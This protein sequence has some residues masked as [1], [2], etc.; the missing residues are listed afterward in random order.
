MEASRERDVSE[1]AVTLQELG[2]KG[3]FKKNS[4]SSKISNSL[5]NSLGTDCEEE[6]YLVLPVGGRGLDGVRVVDVGWGSDVGLWQGWG[7][8]GYTILV[9]HSCR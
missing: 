8:R 7:L 1:P 9:G 4:L 2:V 3:G 6:T 5:T